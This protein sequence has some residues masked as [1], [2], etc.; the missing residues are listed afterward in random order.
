MRKMHFNAGRMAPVEATLEQLG[1]IALMQIPNATARRKYTCDIWDY[2]DY[3][4][5]G[6]SPDSTGTV[7]PGASNGD[8]SL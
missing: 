2:L 5:P 8:S 1:H 7:A 6:A 4:A 3:V